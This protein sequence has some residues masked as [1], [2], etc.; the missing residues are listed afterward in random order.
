MEYWTNY[1]NGYKIDPHVHFYDNRYAHITLYDIALGNNSTGC[2]LNVVINPYEWTGGNRRVYFWK[3]AQPDTQPPTC[4]NLIDTNRFGSPRQVRLGQATWWQGSPPY[5]IINANTMETSET[6]AI[7]NINELLRNRSAFP[8]HMVNGL[9][10]LLEDLINS[11]RSNINDPIIR[12]QDARFGN[13]AGGGAD[14]DY[15]KL[16][17]K[18]MKYKSKYM[19]AKK[20]IE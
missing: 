20:K 5:S 4:S 6:Y 11:G 7:R 2:K 13:F 8:G 3:I 19:D 10:A 1:P 12:L 14:A 17:K 16:Y 9:M 15:N 18:Y